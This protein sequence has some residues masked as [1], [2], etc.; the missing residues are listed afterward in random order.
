M[1]SIARDGEV[2]RQEF[3]AKSGLG[4][5]PHSAVLNN[6]DRGAF[7]WPNFAEVLAGY[8]TDFLNW[9][10]DKG[11]IVTDHRAPAVMSG[12]CPGGEMGAERAI[13]AM[14]Q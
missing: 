3:R 4:S 8:R 5:H 2:N 10:K 1:Q 11:P 13:S 6:R 14:E 9:N 12:R 7:C